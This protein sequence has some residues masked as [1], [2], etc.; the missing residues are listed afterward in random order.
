LGYAYINTSNNLEAKI[1]LFSVIQ[2]TAALSVACLVVTAGVIVANSEPAQAGAFQ[3]VS[4]LKLQDCARFTDNTFNCKPRS[5][6]DYD[7]FCKQSWGLMKTSAFKLPMIFYVNQVNGDRTWK[8]VPRW[9]N[10]HVWGH[11]SLG[12]CVINDGHRYQ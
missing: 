8:A 6:S 2:R 12:V 10:R 11:V 1:M 7:T 4:D 9:E 3:K 5:Q